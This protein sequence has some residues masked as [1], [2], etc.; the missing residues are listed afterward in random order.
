MKWLAI[1]LG[2][3]A[4]LAA[5]ITIVGAL[6][7]ADHEAVVTV[8]LGAGRDS[9]WATVTDFASTSQWFKEVSSSERIADIDGR[10]AWKENYGGFEA[11]IVERERVEGTHVMREILP[12]GSFSGTWTFDLEGDGAGTRLTITERGHVGNPFF[13]G[14]MAFGDETK[15]ARAY[16]ESLGRR[17]GTPTEVVVAP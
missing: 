3:L 16:A 12:A 7:P 13:R 15:T 4:G 10:P 6:R 17:L 2:T 14:M 1:I 9:V 11:T 5:L 8:R